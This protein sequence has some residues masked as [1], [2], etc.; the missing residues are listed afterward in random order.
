MIAVP[1]GWTTLLHV[2]G[3]TVIPPQG[4]AAALV[5][6]V[7]R[8]RPLASAADILAERLASHRRFKPATPPTVERLVT[9]EGEYGAFVTV[10][11]SLGTQAAQYSLGLVFGDDFYARIEGFCLQPALQDAFAQVVRKLA[12]EDRHL[13]GIRRRR[14][15]YASNGWRAIARG[16]LT[17][18]LCEDYPRVNAMAT[19]YPAVPV[20]SG[21]ATQAWAA[22][23]A[24][25][26]GTPFQS[27]SWQPVV[28]RDDIA[29]RLKGRLAESRGVVDGVERLF[30]MVLLEDSRYS[31]SAELL[32]LSAA[33]FD[34]HRAGF[35]RMWETFEAIPEGGSSPPVVAIVPAD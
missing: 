22:A 25:R 30:S 26:L 31:Y 9:V 33:H 35:R 1:E 21:T 20:S 10:Q 28:V 8:V 14:F 27:T 3:L 13:L 2:D 32:S 7:E 17:D 12:Q 24:S 4:P 34:A 19:V 23:R 29:G 6:Y 16:F 18:W 15:M 5:R 11:G